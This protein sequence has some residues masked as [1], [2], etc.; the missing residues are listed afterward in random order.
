[1]TTRVGIAVRMAFLREA[2]DNW[3]S[4]TGRFQ[5]TGQAST[6]DEAVALM[7]ETDPDVVLLDVN[8][9]GLQ[10]LQDVAAIA[11]RFPNVDIVVLAEE[12]DRENIAAAV[13]RGAAGYVSLTWRATDLVRI[14][15][16]VAAGKRLRL[17]DLHYNSASARSAN[18]RRS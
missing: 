9:P 2:A 16:S 12:G 8:L 14:I 18:P 5:I 11:E 3:L 13:R 10:G 1:M 6:A 4:S 17:P 7:E 15:R